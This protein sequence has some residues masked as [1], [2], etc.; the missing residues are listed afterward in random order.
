MT[1]RRPLRILLSIRL[2][3]VI[4]ILST[5]N[6]LVHGTQCCS[7]LPVRQEPNNRAHHS[8]LPKLF[9]DPSTSAESAAKFRFLING[10]D[11]YD[12]DSID[13]FKAFYALPRFKVVN[14]VSLV[15]SGIS[16]K[17]NTLLP[18]SWMLKLEDPSQG[19]ITIYVRGFPLRTPTLLYPL[20]T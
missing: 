10:V 8:L 6:L 15:G 19:E 13:L 3:L 20:I 9:S 17:I 18:N 1:S 2:N 4:L 14:S 11:E 16:L 12:R 5:H 7:R